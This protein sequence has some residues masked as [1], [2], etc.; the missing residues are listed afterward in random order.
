V[1]RRQTSR[2]RFAVYFSPACFC[3]NR[4]I[5]AL[6]AG[7]RLIDLSRLHND[8]VFYRSIAIWRFS[9]NRPEQDP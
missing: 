3:F 1:W 5:I 2:Y 8:E 7:R 9:C 4:W 6:P